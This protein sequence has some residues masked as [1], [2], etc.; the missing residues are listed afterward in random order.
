MANGGGS[1]APLPKRPA[2]VRAIAGAGDD[3]VR[4]IEPAQQKVGFV[5]LKDLSEEQQLQVLKIAEETVKVGSPATQDS[6]GRV[7]TGT[8]TPP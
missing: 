3:V 7:G 8:R 4:A 1:H 2:L 5:E 6:T